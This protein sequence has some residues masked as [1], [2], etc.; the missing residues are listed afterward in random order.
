[1]RCNYFFTTSSLIVAILFSIGGNIA[2]ATSDITRTINFKTDFGAVPY[3]ETLTIPAQT[4]SYYRSLSHPYA[5][6]QYPNGNSMDYSQ[7]MAPDIVQNI[8]IGV[9]SVA[10][11][12]EEDIADTVLSFVQNVGYVSNAYTYGNTLYPIETLATGGVCDD[13]SVLYAS[14]MVSLGFKAILIWYPKQIDLGGSKVTHVNVGVHLTVPP[15][16]TTYGTYSYFTE[17]GDNY[18]NAETTSD[19]W[20]VGDEPPI[21]QN[22]LDNVEVAPMPIS[23][24]VIFT[25]TTTQTQTQYFT[26]T[27]VTTVTTTQPF[28]KSSYTLPLLASFLAALALMGI[29]GHQ[30]GRRKK[31]PIAEQKATSTYSESVPLSVRTKFCR[32]CGTQ[33]P[34]ASKHCEKCGTRFLNHT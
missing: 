29:V 2:T 24:L 4:L 9:A 14:M 20:R 30:I 17:N 11:F 33:M 18:Y 1:L 8:A 26:E 6:L 31:E 23:P 5:L 7:Y 25:M 16:H 27:S 15:E 28:F 12:G 34:I 13:L 32:E 21:L 3:T 10:K 22:T 19:G